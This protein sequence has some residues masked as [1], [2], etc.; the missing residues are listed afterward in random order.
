V[1]QNVIFQ[2]QESIGFMYNLPR[3]LKCCNQD[4]FSELECVKKVRGRLVKTEFVILGDWND[5]QMNW[6]HTHIWD[7]FYMMDGRRDESY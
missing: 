6:P 3:S 7:S 2:I 5:F 1:K 4:F